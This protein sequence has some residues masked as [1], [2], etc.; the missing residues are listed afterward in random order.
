MSEQQNSPRSAGFIIENA[1]LVV[2]SAH[3][4]DMSFV[5]AA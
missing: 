4:V 3:S 2:A 5:L 1:S